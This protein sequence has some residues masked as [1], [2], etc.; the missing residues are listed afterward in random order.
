MNYL[1]S[2]VAIGCLATL[3]LLLFGCGKKETAAPLQPRNPAASPAA[4][5]SSGE[6]SSAPAPAPAATAPATATP[7]TT[8]TTPAPSGAPKQYKTPQEAKEAWVREHTQTPEEARAIEQQQQQ[9]QQ[10]Q[11]Q[12]Q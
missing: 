5:P 11:P 10:Q 4:A 8:A 6:Q 7:A 3:C 9:Q 1:R 12:G 2:L